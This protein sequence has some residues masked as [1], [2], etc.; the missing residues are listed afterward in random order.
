MLGVLTKSAACAFI[1]LFFAALLPHLYAFQT[2]DEKNAKT[3][4]KPIPLCWKFESEALLDTPAV[5]NAKGFLY[6][7]V[8]DGGVTAVDAATGKQAWRSGLGG[9]IVSM[10]A[11]E[12]GRLIVVTRQEGQ[13]KTSLFINSLSEESGVSAWRKEIGP[14]ASS[15]ENFYLLTKANSIFLAREDGHVTAFNAASGDLLWQTSAGGKLTTEPVLT[16]SGMVLGAADKKLILI[17]PDNGKISQTLPA[18]TEPNGPIMAAGDLIVYSDQVGNIFGASLL[19]GELL[20]KARAG[21]EV[22]DISPTGFGI[23]ISSND[24]FAYM[25]SATRGDRKW[26]R[27]FSGRL[28]GKPVLRENYALFVTTAGTEAVILNLANGKFVNNVS[29]L[30]EAY[31][32]GASVA[33]ADGFALFT[34]RGTL[35]YSPTNCKTK[36]NGPV[37]G[38][39]N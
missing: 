22:S 2:N 4:E 31:F 17:N 8:A 9:E 34:S 13:H 33:I 3:W 7:A 12:N 27:K 36:S 37:P 23:L 21:A 29:L 16:E 19:S 20:W 24:N 39:P 35:F 14:L 18:L 32:T 1:L 15:A 11:A 5:T 26:K 10:R 38:T 28:A 30:D 25:L 6:I